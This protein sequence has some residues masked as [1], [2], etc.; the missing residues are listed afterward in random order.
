M[1]RRHVVGRVAGF[2][3]ASIIVVFFVRE[4]QRPKREAIAVLQQLEQMVR[5]DSTA[6]IERVIVVP[7]VVR[8]RSPS[9]KARLLRE[10]FQ[11]EV[12]TEGIE[13]LRKVGTW[14][15]LLDVF[16]DEAGRWTESTGIDPARCMALRNDGPDF[17]SEV[18]LVNDDN[19]LRVLRCNDVR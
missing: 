11:N 16:P 17:R 10:I 4:H 7:E 19:Q 9:E 1:N 14:G 6:Q 18:V 12:T 5:A 3:V 15:P 13:S 2:V 8:D